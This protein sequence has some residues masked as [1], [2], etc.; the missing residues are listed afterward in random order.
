M[1]VI[2]QAVSL[3]ETNPELVI[4]TWS[5]RS[6]AAHMMNMTRPPFTDVRVRHAMQ[7]A[8]DLEAMND[9]YFLGYGD[10]IPRGMV[11]R[12][13]REAMTPFEEWPE[14]L[15]QYYRYDP[16]GAEALLDEAGYP[17]GAGRHEVQG[18]VHSLPALRRELGRTVR[19][20]LA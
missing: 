13:F 1:N 20:V 18:R 12:E 14:E 16:E 9:T 4:H 7:M 19:R 17:R 10:T 3:Q 2:D 6:N 15:T 5:E 8:L 11:G